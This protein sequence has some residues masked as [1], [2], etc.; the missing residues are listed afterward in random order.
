[1][2][3]K[4]MTTKKKNE[5]VTEAKQPVTVVN[6]QHWDKP[7]WRGVASDENGVG[8]TSRTATL[9]IIGTSLGILVYL[10]WRNDRI[11]DHLMELGWFSSLLTTAVYSP[12]KLASVFTSYKARK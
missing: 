3:V 4:Y 7:F 5:K 2:R 12:A 1:M 9:A 6:P 8:S 10:V 11:P